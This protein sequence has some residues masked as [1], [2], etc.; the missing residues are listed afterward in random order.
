MSKDWINGVTREIVNCPDGSINDPANWL[1][2][3]DV[4]CVPYSKLQFIL[5]AGGCLMWVVAY[6]ILV[7]N[8]HK[9]KFVEMAA[10]AAASNFAWE[11]LWAFP[12][13]TDMGKFLVYTYKARLFL[14]CY[15]FYVLLKYGHKQFDEGTWL[16]KNF[17]SWM[18]PTLSFFLAFYY[19]FTK[20][21]MDESIGANSAYI[22]QIFISVFC[23][24]VLMRAKT[25]KGFSFHF[26]W[27]RGFGTGFNT[28]FMYLH[29][30]DNHLVQ[31]L[32]TTSF[33][34]DMSYLYLFKKK[35]KQLA[36]T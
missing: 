23:P 33:I 28:V 5:F 1:N 10:L 4:H 12:F 21:G 25:L 36:T 11:F 20:Q 13:G 26:A 3:V 16:R 7:Y 9:D 19:F 22:C 27:L 17:I 29:Y 31:T 34:L 30:P 24:L 2:W 6:A 8:G 18:I 35:E 32:G 14:D 15:I